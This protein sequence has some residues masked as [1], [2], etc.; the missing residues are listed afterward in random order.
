MRHLR[1]AA[2]IGAL[3]LSA[4]C[5]GGG[6]RALTRVSGTTSTE[7]PT[8][9]SST[10][11]TASPP[12][13]AP[14]AAPAPAPSHPR[15]P[16]PAAGTSCATGPE[17]PPQ[18]I[19]ASF[20]TALAFAPDGR[21][22]FT[23]R[24]GTVR[25]VQGGT[26]KVFAT[27][28]TVTTE[29]G[30]GYSERGLLGLAIS[31]TFTQ[32][33][34]V[35]AFYSNA[36]RVHQSVVRWTDCGGV[37]TNPTTLIVLPAGDDCCH[38]GGRLAFGPDGRLYVTLGEEHTA[39]AAQDTSDV[40][41][42]VLRYN[43]DGSVPPDNPFGATNPVWAYGFRNPFGIAF[44]STGQLAITNN[45]PTGDA[46]SPSTG[47]DTVVESV[48]RGGG[49]EWPNCYGYSHPLASR[50]CG[51]GE[52]EPDWSSESSTV[53]PTGATFVDADGPSGYAGHLV[54]CTF[55][56]GMEILTPGSPHATV[57]PGPSGCHLDVKEGPDHA[58]YYADTGGITRLG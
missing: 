48:V 9:S 43:P 15:T 45:G 8:S 41:G 51:A 56:A 6:S 42:K 23:E 47:Y 40:R 30:G 37:G 26:A 54:F 34:Y 53:V 39:P 3:S 35:Y 50:S 29:P 16:A 18:H 21:L 52:Y 28:A 25:V 5:G 12:A 2:A 7:A 31:P 19:A 46:G 58:L 10:T 36:D 14:T 38:K 17:T 4:A 49:Y 57:A 24:E 20:P 44:S 32:D 27:V 1:I 13:P 11:S 22:F 55:D 33:R